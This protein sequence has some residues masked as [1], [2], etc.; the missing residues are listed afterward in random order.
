LER[1]RD[2]PRAKVFGFRASYLPVTWFEL[3]LTRM[4]Q[5]NGRGRNQSFPS[6]VIKTYFGSG[7]ELNNGVNEMA[8]VDF[9][10]TIPRTNYL[11]PFPSGLQFY[12]EIGSEDKWTKFPLPSRAAV[13]G[14]IY[15]PQLFAGDTMDLRF[16]YADTD[17]DRRRTG[18]ANDWYNSATYRSGMRYRGFPL[19]HWMGTDATDYFLRTTR[20]LRDDLQVGANLEYS[21]RGKGNPAF[22][23]KRE[24]ALDL[25]WWISKQF[26]LTVAY[27]YQRI[28]N[29]GQITRINPFQETF[30][31]GLLSNNNFV[32]TNLAFEF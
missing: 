32:W 4:T 27:T 18:M 28:E 20:H 22:E 23:K 9:K 5:F 3:G 1:D 10:A 17:L 14:G 12:G 16:E 2:A 30:Q 7:D 21:E 8:M 31:S 6:T 24:A 25:T 26:Q 13:L 15:I 19:G 11:I 29:P